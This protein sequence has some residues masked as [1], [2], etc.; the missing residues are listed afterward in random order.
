MARQVM[1][2]TWELTTLI[3][4]SGQSIRPTFYFFLFLFH[5]SQFHLISPLIQIHWSLISY[6][7]RVGLPGVSTE[8]SIKRCSMARQ[9]PSYQGWM[10]QTSRVKKVFALSKQNNQR[11]PYSNYKHSPQNCKLNNHN[12]YTEDLVQTNT[13]SMMAVSVSISHVLLVSLAHLTL[14][15]HLPL[16]L[17]GF[18]SSA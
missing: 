16:L 7:K 2:L 17:W 18:L 8:H 1:G 3:L 11:H 10:K 12:I 4:L 14:M 6:P 15:I 9:N 5:S 13:G